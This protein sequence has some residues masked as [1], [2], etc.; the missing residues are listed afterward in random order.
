M[1]EVEDVEGVVMLSDDDIAEVEEDDCIS[2]AA[3]DI[4]FVKDDIAHPVHDPAEFASAICGV[5]V[6]GPGACGG[7]AVSG[8]PAAA[9]RTFCTYTSSVLLAW[10][11]IA[12][13]LSISDGQMAGRMRVAQSS[14]E[15][16]S[17]VTA[18]ACKA[19][20]LACRKGSLRDLENAA[21][22]TFALDDT[23]KFLA[24]LPRQIVVL[25]RIPGCSSLA[26]LARYFS[27][28]PLMVR[29]ESLLM[30]VS[31]DLSVCSLRR[32]SVQQFHF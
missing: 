12:F 29:S 26:V 8:M 24:I 22:N 9:F 14:S 25:V 21:I 18:K 28:S 4:L 6:L 7:S 30:I 11:R 17:E 20:F 19:A 31:T 10:S 23:P 1:V 5:L 32:V 2:P 13:S 15:K 16:Y 3:V 27:N